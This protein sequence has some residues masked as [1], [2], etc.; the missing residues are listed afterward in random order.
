MCRSI[1]EAALQDRIDDAEMQELGFARKGANFAL[2]DYVR[3][4]LLKSL[5]RAC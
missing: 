5:H 1:V 2:V 3:A 4:A